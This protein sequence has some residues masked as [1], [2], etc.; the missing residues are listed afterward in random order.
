MKDQVSAT[1]PPL[2]EPTKGQ[3]IVASSFTH[4]SLRKPRRIKLPVRYDSLTY[5][6]P[7]I[8]CAN[9]LKLHWTSSAWNEFQVLFRVAVVLH[10][11]WGAC[12]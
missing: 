1:N 2:D 11:Q 8:A 3:T 12:A 4:T 7:Q 6:A 5:D 10:P 9:F